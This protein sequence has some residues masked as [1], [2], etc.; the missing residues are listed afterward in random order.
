MV[1]EKN[2]QFVQNK[3]MFYY[4]FEYLQFFISIFTHVLLQ[5]TC[6]HEEESKVNDTSFMT[7]HQMFKVFIHEY[8]AYLNSVKQHFSIV[9]Y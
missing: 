1:H 4:C 9:E 6:S 8:T 5:H 3:T 7:L 2:T